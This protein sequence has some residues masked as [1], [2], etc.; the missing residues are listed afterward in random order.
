[1]G[2]GISRL[3]EA[4]VALVG[5]VVSRPVRALAGVGEKH[6]ASV[7]IDP[8]RTRS[9]TPGVASIDSIAVL[10]THSMS[11]RFSAISLGLLA[12]L[13]AAGRPGAAELLQATAEEQGLYAVRTGEQ[14]IVRRIG[15]EGTSIDAPL[16]SDLYSLRP[17]THGW[18]AAGHALTDTGDADLLLVQ[19]F[20]GQ[21]EMLPLPDKGAGML[22]G[23]PVVLVSDG[24]LAGLAWVEGDRQ[25]DLQVWAA[26]W[27]GNEWGETE[28]VSGP[29]PGSQLA[30]AGAVL[31]DGSWLLVWTGFD[32]EDDETLFSRKVQGI[33]STPELV[34]ADNQVPD[35]TPALV[36]LRD[37]AV[38]AWSWFDGSDYRIKTARFDGHDWTVNEA[39]GGK[40]SVYPRLVSTELGA[41][42][43][44]HSVSPETWT[45]VEVDAAGLLSRISTL[46]KSTRSRPL[47]LG[48]TSDEVR[49]A[50]PSET[51]MIDGASIRK[52]PWEPL[53]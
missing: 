48:P 15:S 40:G 30:L 5:F 10:P 20:E 27:T 42:L 36:A 45:V 16:S 35:I 14:L 39:M 3:A 25:S 22:R 51:G 53:R 24:S 11:N 1:M 31:E 28:S 7:T 9:G 38:A 23:Q 34:H 47:L 46:P 52:R 6:R 49:I 37:G 12:L 17:T 50:W 26:R 4:S 29:G 8:G 19:Q 41:Q 21:L 33:W 44:F 13:S 2:E 43:L 18:V 32:G